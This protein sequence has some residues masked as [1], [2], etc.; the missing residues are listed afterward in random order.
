[1][2]D[3]HVYSALCDCVANGMYAWAN[4]ASAQTL[5]FPVNKK[6]NEPF[7]V[8]GPPHHLLVAVPCRLHP[9]NSSI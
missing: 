4:W 5:A 3:D 1:M 2:I 9:R 8:L 6:R 7:E